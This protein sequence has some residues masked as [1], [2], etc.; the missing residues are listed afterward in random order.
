MDNRNRK[1]SDN[2]QKVSVH[3]NGMLD[4][5]TYAKNYSDQGMYVV[6]NSLIYPK[7][8]QLEITFDDE[9]NVTR[10]A[11]AKVVHRD[12]YGIGVQF[13]NVQKEAC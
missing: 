1:R 4:C 2:Y 5:N 11:F 9:N 3:K 7:G 6:T 13:E 12:L 8:S 10:H